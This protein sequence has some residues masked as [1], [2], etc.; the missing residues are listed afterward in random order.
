M[1]YTDVPVQNISQNYS[2][3]IYLR[4]L[5]DS[6]DQS[7]QDYQLA[8][9]AMANQKKISLASS[10]AALADQIYT[11]TVFSTFIKQAPKFLT[12][13]P[14]V[15]LPKIWD[16]FDKTAYTEPQY[17][18][19]SLGLKL[20]SW[21]GYTYV[22]TNCFKFE[23]VVKDSYPQIDFLDMAVLFTS[24]FM[25]TFHNVDGGKLVT[26]TGKV[27]PTMLTQFSTVVNNAAN[28]GFRCLYKFNYQGE[29]HLGILNKYT[30]DGTTCKMELL[31]VK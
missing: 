31:L 21:I 14:P 17:R 11:N 13:S 12:T 5:D 4:W 6:A 24:Y 15:Q 20:G 30:T 25:N 2:K 7:L 22:A 23:G 1:D 26:I 29:S 9:K 18:A 10:Y 3:T 19:K 27:D 16:T 8:T 28:E